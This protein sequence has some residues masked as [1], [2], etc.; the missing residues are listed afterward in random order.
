MPKCPFCSSENIERMV[1]GD[2]I[3]KRYEKKISSGM[4]LMTETGTQNYPIDKFIC[5]DCGYVFEKMNT[6]NLEDYNQNK[7]Y[8]TN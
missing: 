4:S 2:Y 5:L 1:S 6:K 8:F 3:Y 7:Q